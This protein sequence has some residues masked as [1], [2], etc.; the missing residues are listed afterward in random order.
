MAHRRITV[1]GAGYVRLTVGACFSSLVHSI[2]C[3]ILI[4]RKSEISAPAG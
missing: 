1:I 3:A 4:H 2:M